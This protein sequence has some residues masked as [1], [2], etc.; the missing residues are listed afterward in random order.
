MGQEERLAGLAF[1]WKNGQAYTGNW[2]DDHD[3]L[4]AGDDAARRPRTLPRDNHSGRSTRQ[5]VK[6][7]LLVNRRLQGRLS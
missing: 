4:R 2:K 3:R 6:L 5:S 7:T 1:T